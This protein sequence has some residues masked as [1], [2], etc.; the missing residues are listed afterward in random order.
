MASGRVPKTMRIFFIVSFSYLACGIYAVVPEVEKFR[1]HAT[2]LPGWWWHFQ[3]KWICEYFLLC[4]SQ[5]EPT[6]P[7]F[8]I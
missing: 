8:C 3:D 4:I 1:E 5:F 2:A 6:E 7:V